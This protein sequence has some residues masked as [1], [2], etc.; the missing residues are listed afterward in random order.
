MYWM[1][2]CYAA[3]DGPGRPIEPAPSAPNVGSWLSGAPL[4]M[5]PATPIRLRFSVELSEGKPKHLYKAG[6]P[7]LSG[8]L[9]RALRE[10][11]VDNLETFPAMVSDPLTGESLRYAAF[12]VIGLI[13]AADM[14]ASV[15]DTA[16]G[17]PLIAVDF[18]SVVLDEK[19]IR[20]V[21]LFRLAEN[22]C[23]IVIQDRVKQRLE[24]ANLGLE[25][26]EPKDWAG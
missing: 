26:I 15:Y 3:P 24:A 2:E 23:A 7:L 11:G 5:A 22:V 12:N 16:G 9:F 1:L 18:D 8:E 13:A 10:A 6:I 14:G 17:P 20:G 21:R 19:K 25:F 4:T